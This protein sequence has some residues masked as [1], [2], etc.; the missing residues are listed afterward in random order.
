MGWSMVDSSRGGRVLLN[1]ALGCVGICRAKTIGVDLHL[2]VVLQC[3]VWH[4]VCVSLRIEYIYCN[5]GMC[6]GYTAGL[7]CLN[8]RSGWIKIPDVIS[9]Q[10]SVNWLTEWSSS[11]MKEIYI[12][13]STPVDGG[14]WFWEH[15]FTDAE[16]EVG[17]V[18]KSLDIKILHSSLNNIGYVKWNYMPEATREGLKHLVYHYYYYHYS[19]TNYNSWCT[20]LVMLVA[21]CSVVPYQWSICKTL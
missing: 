9:G 1:C 17:F 12:S 14:V 20:C 21:L 16:L 8:L 15:W 13:G 18:P 19:L 11:D 2:E 4:S 10:G 6:Y 7:S 3:S 5:G